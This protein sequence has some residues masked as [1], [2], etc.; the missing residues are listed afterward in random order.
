MSPD[1]IRF[2]IEVLTKASLI[3]YRQQD[4]ALTRVGRAYLE[5][6]GRD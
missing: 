6:M 3:V 4:C 5:K 2:H 1:E